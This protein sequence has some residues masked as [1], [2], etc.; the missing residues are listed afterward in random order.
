MH[1]TVKQVEPVSG[2]RAAELRKILE[3]RRQDLMHDLQRRVRQRCTG[4]AV[5]VGDSADI[6]EADIQDDMDL[7]LMQIK[8]EMLDHIQHALGRL[9]AGTF[10]FCVECNA[11]ISEQRLRALPFALRCTSCEERRERRTRRQPPVP[12]FSGAAFDVR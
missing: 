7:A 12:M 3:G 6:A 10:G 2:D 5:D 8:T 11:E 1:Q 4:S 9:D